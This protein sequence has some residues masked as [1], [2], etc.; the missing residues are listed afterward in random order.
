MQAEGLKT[1]QRVK[2]LGYGG[3]LP[4]VGLLVAVVI[5]P[6]HRQY[7]AG[8][9][10]SYGAVI[11][12]FVAGL[13]WAFA[14]TLQPLDESRRGR[15]LLWSVVPPLIGWLALLLPPLY[16]N[17]L[18]I[19]AFSAHYWFDRR[20]ARSTQA[21]PGWYLPLRLNLTLAACLSLLGAALVMAYGWS[22]ERQTWV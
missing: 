4:F 10:A 3:L 11:L 6:H 22:P 17:G 5:D 12:S 1:A 19:S 14:M 20:L 16:A 8:A 13:H 9:Q 21:L 15:L 2:W 7:W 18:L